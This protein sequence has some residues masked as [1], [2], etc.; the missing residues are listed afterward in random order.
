MQFCCPCSS[1][2]TLTALY[3]Y[4]CQ[5]HISSYQSCFSLVHSLM[6]SFGMLTIVELHYNRAMSFLALWASS[7]SQNSFLIRRS[8][9]QSTI[10]ISVGLWTALC[11]CI[12]CKITTRRKRNITN[13]AV[14]ELS[15]LLVLIVSSSHFHKCETR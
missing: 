11:F 1:S 3:Y 13:L 6:L 9:K 2:C 8:C 14:K 12:N 7:R 4:H 15:D 10:K 5:I